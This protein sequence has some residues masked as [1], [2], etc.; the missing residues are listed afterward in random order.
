MQPGR[1]H[2]GRGDR[3][4]LV[5]RQFAVDG[6]RGMECDRRR[7]RVLHVRWRQGRSVRMYRSPCGS[8]S[9]RSAADSA[10]ANNLDNLR[11]CRWKAA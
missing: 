3:H 4:R 1:S 5:Q 10:T 7:G 9:L 8:G 6:P 2:S 11:L